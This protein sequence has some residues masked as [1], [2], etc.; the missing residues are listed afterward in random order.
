MRRIEAARCSVLPVQ[1]PFNDE[2]RARAG[3]GPEWYLP[4]AAKE[5]VAGGGPQQGSGNGHPDTSTAGADAGA[6]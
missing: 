1:P 3:F 5:A 2:A 6:V 4:L